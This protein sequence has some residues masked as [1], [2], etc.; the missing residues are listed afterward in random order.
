MLHIAFVP[1]SQAQDNISYG[2]DTYWYINILY[3]QTKLTVKRTREVI[4]LIDF[5]QLPL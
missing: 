5:A 2:A 1:R 3:S 4:P